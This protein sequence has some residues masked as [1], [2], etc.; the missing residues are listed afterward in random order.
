MGPLMGLT[1][2][3]KRKRHWVSSLP[4]ENTARQYL[5]TRKRALAKN[6]VFSSL[7]LDFPA[8]REGRDKS[9]L[10]TP[11]SP[12]IRYSS[13]SGLRVDFQPMSF[14]RCLWFTVV[15]AML[16]GVPPESLFLMA[17]TCVLSQGT[18]S[19]QRPLERVPMWKRQSRMVKLF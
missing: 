3:H 9:L 16:C 6:E 5:Q 19:C 17:M 11:C 12:S 13:P 2:L 1:P 18:E 8:P 15:K 10:F 14:S 4:H 7:N